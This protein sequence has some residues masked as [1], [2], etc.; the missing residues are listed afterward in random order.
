MTAMRIVYFSDVHIEIRE[1]QPAAPWSD[2]LPLGFGPEL[3][4]F[5]GAA[6][7]R[8]RRAAVTTLLTEPG[9][10]AWPRPSA[11]IGLHH[12]RVGGTG[13]PPRA[14]TGLCGNDPWGTEAIVSADPGAIVKVGYGA[15]GASP[16]Y[17]LN[18]SYVIGKEPLAPT[19][20]GGR[21]APKAA[22][23]DVF[24]GAMTRHRLAVGLRAPR[25]QFLS[26]SGFG[27][28][29]AQIVASN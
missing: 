20:R 23:A 6:D 12:A 9:G 29:A 8:A 2:T 22:I 18:A 19:L 16:A 28:L 17:R 24:D 1:S 21:D 27:R 13:I 14:T 25:L 26:L 4:T 7:L 3:S 11:L 15:R 10:G 5:V